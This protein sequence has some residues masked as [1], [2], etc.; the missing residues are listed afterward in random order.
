MAKL[1]NLNIMAK[2]S[3]FQRVVQVFVIT[4]MA[5]CFFI[6][7]TLQMGQKTS[8]KHYIRR[9]N[10]RTVDVQRKQSRISDLDYSYGDINQTSTNH[11][12][13]SQKVTYHFQIKNTTRNFYEFDFKAAEMSS[14]VNAWRENRKKTKGKPVDTMAMVRFW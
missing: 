12:V 14:F 6:F 1:N 13:F 10:H 8:P 2:L 9:P 4:G 3:S 11:L 7:V 5:G